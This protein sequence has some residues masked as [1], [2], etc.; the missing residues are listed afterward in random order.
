MRWIAEFEIRCNIPKVVATVK[1]IHMRCLYFVAK[2]SLNVKS[3]N[4]VSNKTSLQLGFNAST[5]TPIINPTY[6]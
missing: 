2:N 1:V 5:Q 3:S 6:T 4:I